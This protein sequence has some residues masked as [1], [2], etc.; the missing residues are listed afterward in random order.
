MKK[1][2]EKTILWKKKSKTIINLFSF[3]FAIRSNYY[4]L[5]DALAIFSFGDEML[6][7]KNELKICLIKLVLPN[8][9]VIFCVH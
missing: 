9:M 2:N 6:Q 7:L 8:L 3:Y 1:K 4:K 5:I